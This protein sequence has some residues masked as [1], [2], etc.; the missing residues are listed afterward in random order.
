LLTPNCIVKKKQ[1]KQAQLNFQL[2]VEEKE[3]QKKQNQQ[4]DKLNAEIESYLSKLCDD[5][6]QQIEAA[7]NSS[8][9]AS[10]LKFGQQKVDLS[11]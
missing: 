6:L 5:E 8:I 3:Q 11:K 2:D 10:G 9:F 1:V 7:F 4:A